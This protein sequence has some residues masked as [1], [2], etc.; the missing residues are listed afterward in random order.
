MASEGLSD[1]LRTY[2]EGIQGQ[3]DI[4]ND[5]AKYIG[6]ENTNQSERNVCGYAVDI[7]R[8]A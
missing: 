7:I 8:R 5:A 1:Q 4:S 3:E 6:R 2:G